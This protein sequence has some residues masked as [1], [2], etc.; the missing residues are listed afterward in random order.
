MATGFPTQPGIGNLTLHPQWSG[1]IT[2]TNSYYVDV[3]H[4]YL[5]HTDFPVAERVWLRPDDVAIGKDTVVEAALLWINQQLA[6][7]MAR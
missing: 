1:R 3:P 6:G 7:A 4:Q 2:E 5:I